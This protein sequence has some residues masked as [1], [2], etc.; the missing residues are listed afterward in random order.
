[1]SIFGPHDH[2][3]GLVERKP[4]LIDIQIRNRPDVTSYRVWGSD[5]INDFYGSPATSDVQGQ[6]RGRISLFDV[7]SGTAFRSPTIARRRIM[8]DEKLGETTR[9][10]FSLDD[11]N[12]IVPGTVTF[13]GV[14]VGDTVV[15]GGITFTGA[16]A[17][18]IGNRE[19][20]ASAGNNAAATSLVAV[21]NDAGNQALIV[22]ANR[23]VTATGAANAAVVTLTVAA[24]V[25]NG[26]LTLT[27]NNTV[28]VVL[29]MFQALPHDQGVLYL[30]LQQRRRT[31]N[32][33]MTVQGA[34]NTGDPILGP[35]VI[36]PPPQFFGMQTPLLSFQGRAPAGTT[37]SFG[38]PPPV[39]PD[40]QIPNPMHIVLPRP[41]RSLVLRNMD[42]ANAL[43]VSFGLGYPMTRLEIGEDLSY[44]QGS[45]KEIV[46]ASAAGTACSF[47]V[48]AAV[49]LDGG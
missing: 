6:P 36:V 41:A 8:L 22:A 37:A 39:D 14:G 1:M 30:R 2:F 24:L 46:L 32:A 43:F 7:A 5:N 28:T 25:V 44:D 42:G 15:I 49:A 23:G 17:Q 4:G 27:T 20:D 26:T 34:A 21:L 31:T 3:P 19:F 10:L 33:L 47:A 13:N 40:I 9:A 29:V 48:D 38:N 11:F 12:N 18:N 45:F 16:A 35:I